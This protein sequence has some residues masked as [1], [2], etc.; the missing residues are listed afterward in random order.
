MSESNLSRFK[1][2]L[3][4]LFMFDQ[5]DLDFGIYRIMNAKRDEITQFLDNDLLPQVRESLAALV[6]GDRTQI[7]SDLA[8]A[9][10]SLRE[11]GSDPESSSKVKELREQLEAQTDIDS[12][13]SEVFSHL[14]E[15]FRRYYSEGDFL[16]LRRYKAGVYAIPY[17]GEEV[18]LHWANADQY[19][20]KTSENFRDFAFIL[21]DGRK[22]HF[23][24]VEADTEPNN[25]RA[26]DGQERRFILSGEDAIAQENGE[27]VIRFDYRPDEE[28]R[29]QN[30]LNSEAVRAIFS[31]NEFIEWNVALAT[32]A[33]TQKNANRTLLEKYL[34]EY[35][36]KNSFDYFIHKDL[37]G[38]L[39]RELDFYIK[40]EVIYL[41]DIESD[42]APRV[43]QY[44]AKVKAIRRIAHKIID[45]LAQLENFQ[46][47]LWL[48]K[49]FI[50]ETNYCLTLD[51]VPKNLYPKI[52]ANENQLSE[53]QN[54]YAIEETKTIGQ[55]LE[56]GELRDEWQF[57][58]IDTRHFDQAFKDVLLAS[59]DDL[60][61]NLGGVCF[62]GDNFHALELM[63]SRYR[64]TVKCIYIDPPY[65]T[66]AS[67]IPYKNDY[68]HSSWGT[69]MRDRL[70]LLKVMLKDAGAIFVSIDKHER[71]ILEYA[72]DTVFS[73]GNRV[74]ELIWVQN[75]NDGRSPTYSTN[76]EYVEV[77]A[78]RKAAVEN[79]YG[80]FRE[81]KPGYEEVM[82]LIGELNPSY[83]AASAV[84]QKLAELYETHRAEYREA[85]EAEG[86][87]Y[88]E[89][90]RNDPWKGLYS[91][92][93][94]EYRDLNGKY[95]SEEEAKEK[96][97]RIWV[98]TES[99]WTIMSAERKQSASIRDPN[100][101]N[102]RFYRPT[103]PITKKPCKISQRGW[104]GTQFIDPQ[105]PE[106]NSFESLMMDHRIVF[107][108]DENKVPRQKRM[109][110]EVESN[111]SKSVF[112]DYADGEKETFALFGKGGLFLAPKHTKF[113]S[114]FVAQGAKA[115]S[116]VLDC[117]GG[118]GSTPHAVINMNRVDE[119]TRKYIVAEVNT[120]FDTLIVPRI[121]KAVFSSVWS[122]GKPQDRKSGISHAFKMVR[123]ESYEDALNNVNVERSSEQSNLLVRH[124]EF[125]EDYTLRYMLD[126]ETRCSASLLN[127][128]SFADPFEYKLNIANHSVGES[129]PVN[130]DLI[131]TFN[132]L[133]G[134]RVNHLDLVSGFRVVKGRNPAGEKVLVIWR[135][136][137]Q[138]SNADLDTFFQKQAYKTGDN[139][140]DLIYVNGDNNLENL[141]RGD[142]TWKVRLIEQE[143]HRLMFDVTD[144]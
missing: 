9:I 91:Y 136:V 17:E 143:F 128:Q 28:K 54:L 46:K 70:A 139:E 95:V 53:W 100:S 138:K 87:D 130:I 96:E 89:E 126:E 7:E 82:A 125:R 121:K 83:P 10:E 129:R 43:E 34:T 40:N 94:V 85:V 63:L 61:A 137:Q 73:R 30:E 32:K 27:L 123:L 72:M 25:Q 58:M 23:K 134:L 74:E 11:L 141:R 19:Y 64:D 48:K 108:E 5:A 113:V 51:R 42:A 111:V 104:K 1:S 76:H 65:N 66:G 114:R 6:S 102:F 98:W 117:F 14:Y 88:E 106:R 13:E 20:I 133:L 37:A 81:A 29:K 41:D 2:L 67:S 107:G 75:T 18:K 144:I 44:L 93:G 21:A 60:D 127:L 35:T 118:S 3:A 52:G 71:T 90:Q 101:P 24:L 45:L 12:I 97:A 135:N 84:E 86:L 124:N 122:Q 38:F 103:H 119:G 39:R 59:I 26:G 132:Y 92:K 120:Y 116:V 33:P 47:K 110:H 115:D 55:Q 31:A 99:D 16:S 80:M 105:H 36:A 62:Y 49:K 56:K 15:F 79:D 140:F 109:L 112:V 57:I 8:K 77:Y 22:V 78:K 142:E 69:L 4:E 50:V 68:K 131:E